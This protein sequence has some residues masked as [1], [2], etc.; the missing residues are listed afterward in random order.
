MH[1]LCIYELY[2][3]H[4]IKCT[5]NKQTNKTTMGYPVRGEV[6]AGT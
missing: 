1:V 4:A 6:N 2:I 5:F 3:H